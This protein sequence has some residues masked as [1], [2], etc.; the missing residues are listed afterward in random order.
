MTKKKPYAAF[1]SFAHP[2][3]E[4]VMCLKSLFGQ[5]NKEVFF[6]LQELRKA[7]TREWRTKIT[8]AIH[9]ST[10]FIPIYTRHSLRREWVLY[11]SGIADAYKLHRLPARVASVS[12]SDIEDL[13]SPGAF[14]YDLS[15]KD[16]LARLIINVCVHD[17]E[18]EAA[19]TPRVYNIVQDSPLAK[20]VCQLS[21]T[22]WVFIAGNYPEDAALPNSGINW[23]TTRQEY[24]DRLKRFCEMLTEA[25]LDQGFSVSACPQVESVGM[26]VINRAVSYLDSVQ[27][28]SDVDFSIGG[29][30]PIDRT[31]RKSSLSETARRK[32]L[33]HIMEFRKSYLSN[34]EWIILI[35]GNEGTKEEHDAARKSKV[36]VMAIP[37]FGGTAAVIH[38]RTAD[39]IKGPC[40]HCEKRKGLCDV[41]DVQ[42]IVSALKGDVS[43]SS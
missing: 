8:E 30:Y 4:L 24:L 7:K 27:H 17:G 35:G 41:K 34:Q 9:D 13:P 38:S 33:D 26:H 14:V 36:K 10:C 5:L 18:D 6:S 11:E 42:Q 22:R 40:A 3:R 2:D 39:N 25:L 23:F 19:F 12:P 29:I 1:L 16:L 15:E 43:R 20:R 37:C 28:P 32:W 31:A 21:L